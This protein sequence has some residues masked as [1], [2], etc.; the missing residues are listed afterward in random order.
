MN[1]VD[2][3]YRFTGTGVNTD[4]LGLFDGRRQLIVYRFFDTPETSPLI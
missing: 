1:E 2:R 4:L 3:D